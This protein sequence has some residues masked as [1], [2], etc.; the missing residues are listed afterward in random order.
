MKRLMIFLI[1]MFL[2]SCSTMPINQQFRTLAFPDGDVM[3]VP[4]DM[5]DFLN[6]PYALIEVMPATYTWRM[7]I[8]ARMA[9]LVNPS[10]MGYYLVLIDENANVL[11]IS[12]Y[13]DKTER[14]W[15]FNTIGNPVEVSKEDIEKMITDRYKREITQEV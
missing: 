13:K 8:F 2:F 15:M 3:N 11:A 6:E 4:I 1:M 12:E 14:W 5:P 10:T 9:D 7:L